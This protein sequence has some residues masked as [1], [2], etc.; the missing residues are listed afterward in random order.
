VTSSD[1]SVAG[2][3]GA[4][5]LI[6]GDEVGAGSFGP[7]PGIG[8][9]TAPDPEP[10]PGTAFDSHCHLEMI[11][12]AV[13]DTLAQAAAAGITR[14][15]TV[16]TDVAS[17]RWA[18]RCAAS[19]RQV[20]AA[21]AIHPNETVVAADSPAGRDATLAEIARLAA[22]PEIRAVGETGLDYYRDSAPP[23]LQR[24]WFRA[25]IDIAKQVGK[26]L[27]IHDRDAH[28][29][30]FAILAAD[31]PPEEVIFHCFSGDATVAER[32][33]A[34]GYVLSFAG[35]VT[36]ANAS[37][38]R[39]AAA[40]TPAE[41]LLAETDAPFLAPAP[42]RG[43]A[44]SPAQVAHTVRALAA[45]KQ[46]DVSKLCAVIEATGDRVFGPWPA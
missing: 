16:G 9:P 15:V 18:A 40:V 35:T 31:G 13:A 7:G 20:A 43:R 8:R 22:L 1:P 32:C 34:A 30:V 14:V 24:D 45:A 36:F 37:D 19:F 10:L 3:P 27:M 6:G 28:A 25:H 11:D 5:R 39:A 38:L 2:Q 44:N 33:V 21:V 46:M 4:G 26:P 23:E 29:D 12:M 42:N 41:L 17:S